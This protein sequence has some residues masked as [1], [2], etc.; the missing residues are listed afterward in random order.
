MTHSP[1]VGE[2]GAPTPPLQLVAKKHFLR[3]DLGNAERFIARHGE[4]VRYVPAWKQW[5]IWDGRRWQPDDTLEVMRLAKS[6]VRAM[7]AEAK[8]LAGDERKDLVRWTMQ[9][10]GDARL[11][12]MVARGAAES[13]IALRPAALDA[14]PMRL[15]V[16]NGVLD[17]RTATLAPHDRTQLTTKLVPVLFDPEARC[18]R[19][20]AFLARVMGG[21]HRLISFLQRAVGYSLTASTAEQCLFF[22]YGFGANGK[23]TFLEILRTIAGEYAT[24]ADFTTFLERKGDGPR[25]DV[26]RLFGARTVTSSEVAEGRRLN[27]SLVKSLTGSDTVAARFLYSETFEFRPAFKLWIAA[28]HRPVIRGVDTGIWRRIRL[29]PFT[30]QIPE[31]EQDKELGAKLRE[32][33]PGILA[34]A[35]AGCVLWQRDGL[36]APAEVQQATDAYRRDSDTLGAFLEDCCELDT[37][38]AVRASELYAVYTEWAAEGGEYQLSQTMFGRQLEERGCTAEKRGRGSERTKWRL[39][40]RLL[41]Q[42]K[43]RPAVD[44]GQE[45]LFV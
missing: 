30:V 18:D 6:T 41:R 4:N 13:G 16:L 31:A 27:E 40:I 3:T 11:R 15:T 19:W 21:N 29:V 34:W 23:T 22:L 38:A 42:P 2:A 37:T 28:N 33:L 5:L 9:S 26:A 1:F 20:E 10:E 17:L 32:E 14:D 8:E 44:H 35:V 45:A 7:W 12:A 36:G 25:N 43:P 39:G 24:Q